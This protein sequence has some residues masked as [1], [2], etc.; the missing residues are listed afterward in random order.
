MDKILPSTC[1]RPRPRPYQRDHSRIARARD[2]ALAYA[3]A[4][5]VDLALAYVSTGI[6]RAIEFALADAIDFT[7]AYDR[8]RDYD[9]ANSIKSRIDLTIANATARNLDH[10]RDLYR[11]RAHDHARAEDIAH[12]RDAARELALVSHGT[13]FHTYNFDVY[14][15]IFILQERIAGRLPAWEGIRL[16]RERV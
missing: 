7:L 2:L 1:S 6:N 13:F 9:I 16:V 4:Q 3:P 5:E 15:A 10:N 11:A 8:T 14:I 12:A